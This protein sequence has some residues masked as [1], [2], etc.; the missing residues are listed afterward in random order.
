M[1]KNLPI[2]V[3]IIV[4]VAGGAFLGGMK[5]GQSTVASNSNAQGQRGAGLRNGRGTGTQSANFVAG[6]IISKDDKSLTIQSRD[7][8]SKIVFYSPSA[9]VEKFVTSTISDL[10]IGENVTVNGKTNSDGSLTAQSIQLR[11]AMMRPAQP[12]QTPPQP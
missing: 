1:K 9:V 11:P 10:A 5:Y 4:L 3:L 7:G 12:G 8:G 6:S 2:M